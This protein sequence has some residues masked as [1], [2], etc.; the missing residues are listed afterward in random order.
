MTKTNRLRLDHQTYSPHRRLPMPCPPELLKRVDA[1]IENL[2]NQRTLPVPF[3]PSVSGAPRNAP[4]SDGK[5][6]QEA[7]SPWGAKPRVPVPI[8]TL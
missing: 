3:Q 6:D 2:F 7:P 4:F 1:A 5:K 8:E